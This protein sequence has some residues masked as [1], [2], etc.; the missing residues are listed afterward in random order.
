MLT[1]DAS[2][3][4]ALERALFEAR[5]RVAD[6]ST[7]VPPLATDQLLALRERAHSAW[8]ALE[9]AKACAAAIH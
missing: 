1:P 5:Q 4:T 6:A 8:V 7:A 9:E 3:V 2:T